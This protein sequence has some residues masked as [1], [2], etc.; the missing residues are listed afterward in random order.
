MCGVPQQT[1]LQP[2]APEPAMRVLPCPTWVPSTCEG[3]A[4]GSL[5]LHKNCFKQL[6]V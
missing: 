5:D 6:T 4:R 1:A 3:R 2:A